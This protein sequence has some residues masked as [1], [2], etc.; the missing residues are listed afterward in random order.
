MS[1][2]ILD[3]FIDVANY[4]RSGYMKLDNPVPKQKLRLVQ[5]RIKFSNDSGSQ[6]GKFIKFRAPWLNGAN[7]STCTQE[8]NIVTDRSFQGITLLTATNR[9]TVE[10]LNLDI[11]MTQDISEGFYF[12]IIGGNFPGLDIAGLENIH[13][14]FQYEKGQI[15]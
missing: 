1:S 4:G 11:E 9:V 15:A 14:I 12:D 10:Y 2:N 13:M 7:F 6:L 8:T 3:I 5:Y